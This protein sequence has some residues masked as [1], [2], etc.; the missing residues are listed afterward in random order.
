M[1]SCN[2]FPD[3]VNNVKMITLLMRC[4]QHQYAMLYRGLHNYIVSMK[5][6]RNISDL[7]QIISDVKFH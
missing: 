3:A 7:L 1:A 5:L 2:F 4:S 6:C